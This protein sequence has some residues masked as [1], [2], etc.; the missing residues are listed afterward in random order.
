VAVTDIILACRVV[1]SL[2][3]ILISVPFVRRGVLELKRRL[4]PAE[5]LLF[6]TVVHFVDGLIPSYHKVK[7][8][9]TSL[10]IA[11]KLVLLVLNNT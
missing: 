5:I 1:P 8:S 10:S 6:P 7:P 3:S 4:L 9:T 2:S 11:V